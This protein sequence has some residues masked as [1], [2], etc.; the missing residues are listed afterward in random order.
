MKGIRARRRGAFESRRFFER[1]SLSHA[2]A[3]DNV[4]D[5]LQENSKKTPTSPNAKR[6]TPIC[7]SPDEA[8]NSAGKV[9]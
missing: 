7:Y 5:L 8:I 9:S 4:V 3:Q 2:T 1:P 6:Q